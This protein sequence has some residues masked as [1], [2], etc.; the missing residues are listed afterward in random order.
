VQWEVM[1]QPAR[2]NMRAAQQEATQQ[3]DGTLKGGSVS[4]GCSATRSHAT[5]NRANGRRRLVKRWQHIERERGVM[6]IGIATTRWGKQ[7]ASACQEAA[8]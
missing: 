2:A 7:E 3:P 6:T 5:T 4:R 1:L 8:A